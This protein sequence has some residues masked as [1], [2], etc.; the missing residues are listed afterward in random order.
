[1]P[2]P[3]RPRPARVARGGGYLT[4]QTEKLVASISRRACGEA[5]AIRLKE[6]PA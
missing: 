5:R 4:P 6:R 3:L 1:M 2:D